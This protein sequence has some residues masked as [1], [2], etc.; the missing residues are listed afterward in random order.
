MDSPAPDLQVSCH[1]SLVHEGDVAFVA[2]RT[3]HLLAGPWVLYVA[4]D[5]VAI[6]IHRV[7][8]AAEA[9]AMDAS[10]AL[11]LLFPARVMSVQLDVAP[12][13]GRHERWRFWVDDEPDVTEVDE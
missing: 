13:G 5:A 7:A 3:A 1:P 8:P 4:S 9:W 10:G 2:E 11:G 6:D 12:R